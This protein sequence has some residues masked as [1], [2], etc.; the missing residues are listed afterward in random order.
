MYFCLDF[1]S[2]T[3]L[4]TWNNNGTENIQIDDNQLFYVQKAQAYLIL[5]NN[6]KKNKKKTI[7]KMTDVHNEAEAKH[8]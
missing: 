5:G 2:V 7:K 3:I 4:I 8:N 6:N 1:T